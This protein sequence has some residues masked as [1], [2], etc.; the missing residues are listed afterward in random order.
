M[1]CA[2]CCKCTAA[3]VCV[4]DAKLD[5]IVTSLR[6]NSRTRSDNQ[7]GPTFGANHA[8]FNTLASALLRTSLNPLLTLF[9]A[10][11]AEI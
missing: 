4:C 9:Y 6:T 7:Q 10:A 8:A 11:S 5:V 1:P 3:L 2:V